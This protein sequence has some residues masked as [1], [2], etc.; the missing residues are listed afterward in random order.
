MSHTHHHENHHHHEVKATS[1]NAFVIG[2]ILNTSFVLIEVGA[3]LWNNSLALLTDAGHNLG[4]VAGLILVLI[5]AKLAKRKP[6]DKFTYGYGKSTILVALTNAAL[7]LVAVGAIGWEAIG[8]ISDSHPVPGK[9]ISLVA[10]VGI[11]INSITAL[12]FMKDRKKDLNVRGAFLHMASDAL[13]SLGVMISGIIIIYT[14]WYWLDAVISLVICAVIVWSTWDLLKDSVNLSLDSVPS[15]VDLKAI[16]EYF[17]G[18]KGVSGIHDL[19]VWALSTNAS[20]LTAHLVA[21]EGISDA[22]LAEINDELHEHFHIDH[23][24]IQVERSEEANCAQEC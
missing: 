22:F 9:I 23:T 8:R 13:V 1:G 10:L 20:A 15:G 14:N 3:G 18:L 21:P 6:T 24:T 2:I 19:H 16:R 5:A 17:L 11:L 4:D 12:L 7:L